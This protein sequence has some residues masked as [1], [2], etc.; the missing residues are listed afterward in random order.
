MKN[1]IF[2]FIAALVFSATVSAQNTVDSIRSK[3]Q[4]QP[5]PGAMTI[6]KTFPVIGTY[7]MTAADGA[8]QNVVITIDSVNKGIVWVEGLPEGK[9]KAYLKR[10]PGTYRIVA[11]KAVNGKQVPEGT[12]LFDPAT[13]TLN[14]ALGKKFD[15]AD[16]AAVFALNPANGSATSIDATASTEVKVKS[17]KG[18]TKT[19][20]KLLFYTATKAEVA[21]STST[22]AA[23]Q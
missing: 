7:Q 9:F 1:T 10:S 21:S 13:N 18:D 22:D 6:E 16:P 11:Q 20:S 15:D 8:M 2:L 19:K 12:L 17:K 23:K 14:V 4:L 5:M 3:Y